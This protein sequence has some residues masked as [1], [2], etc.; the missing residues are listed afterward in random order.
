MATTTTTIHRAP[1]RPLGG[2][3]R[4]A[5]GITLWLLVLGLV[6]AAIAAGLLLR[7]T[8]VE[9]VAAQRRDVTS[10][11]EV[12]GRLEGSG[13]LE[14]GAV[15]SGVVASVAVAPG[16]RVAPGDVLVRLDDRT[17][18]AAVE[19]A[20]AAIALADTRLTEVQQQIGGELTRAEDEVALAQ[21]R[22]D[23]LDQAV[24]DGLLIEA[25]ARPQAQ[26]ELEEATRRREQAAAQAADPDNAPGVRLA[27]AERAQAEATLRHA[28]LV[29]EQRAVRSPVEGVVVERRVE[30]GNTVGAGAPVA[31]VA[32]TGPSRIVLEADQ[33]A[34]EE[35]EE[36]QS[37]R[38]SLAEEPDAPAVD[39][40][41]VRSGRG[42]ALQVEGVPRSWGEG[43][44]VTADVTTSMREQ[45]LAVPLEALRGARTGTPWVLVADGRRVE[46][47]DV[48]VGVVGEGYVEVRG[49]LTEGDE[50]VVGSPTLKPGS[51]IARR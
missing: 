33:P 43:A 3:H 15:A 24:A 34:V 50:V 42:Y 36:G 6:V 22:L 31:V 17:Q 5:W 13:E 40:V 7:G 49:G 11:V 9:T 41:I 32:R 8:H 35:L 25:S 48:D 51:R 29:L 10:T 21:Q 26:A 44:A 20:R 4:G 27:T 2:G 46:R 47:R 1:R 16:Q 23:E 37:A 45:A 14:V 30:P 12:N 38:V 18:V 39:G 19:E 28:E